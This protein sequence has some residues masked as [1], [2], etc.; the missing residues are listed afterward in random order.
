MTKLSKYSDHL[1]HWGALLAAITEN[2]GNLPHLVIP[3]DLLQAYLSEALG[4]TQS[5]A[6]QA[7]A[8]QASSRRLEQ[9]VNLGSKLATSLRFAVKSHY[10]YGSEKLTEFRIQPFRGRR[11]A[12]EP[13]SG[14][15][16]P[17]PDDSAA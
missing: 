1:N 10:G 15:E 2:E 17:A 14:P 16:A 13:P 5:Q 11:A 4:L 9:V 6:A 12:P 8:K 3:R 7:A